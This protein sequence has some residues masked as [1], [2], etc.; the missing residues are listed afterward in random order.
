LRA[1]RFWFGYVG[2]DPSTPTVEPAKTTPL[3]PVW[4]NSESVTDERTTWFEKKT[5]LPPVCV[6]VQFAM[7]TP[8]A[9]STKSAPPRCTAQ[10]PPLGT[11]YIS[12]NVGRECVKV[13]PEKLMSVAYAPAP[14]C[15]PFT[16]M[17]SSAMGTAR[18]AVDRSVPLGKTVSV[19]EEAS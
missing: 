19:L 3:S 12:R 5:P 7:S 9:F 16:T 8:S 18:V 2:A 1:T 17:I 13:K 6:N 4:A 14:L 10:S 15:D 11:S